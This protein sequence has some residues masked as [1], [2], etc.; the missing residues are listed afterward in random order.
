MNDRK[1]T[2]W[3]FSRTRL[4][5]DERTSEG[6]TRVSQG[7][8]VCSTKRLRP[9]ATPFQGFGLAASGQRSSRGPLSLSAPTFLRARLV[10]PGGTGQ[11]GLRLRLAQDRP[12]L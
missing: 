9:R 11:P 3:W 12:T 5:A 1:A 10:A 7:S 2:A 6:W 8:Q 4:S